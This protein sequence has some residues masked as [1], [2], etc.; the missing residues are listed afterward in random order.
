MYKYFTE[1]NL[2][3]HLLVKR[4]GLNFHELTD[5]QIFQENIK[6]DLVLLQFKLVRRESLKV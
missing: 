5:E 2:K 3:N 4:H 6:N 1:A